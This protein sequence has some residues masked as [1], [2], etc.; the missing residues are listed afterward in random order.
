MELKACPVCLRSDMVSFSDKTVEAFDVQC[1]RCGISGPRTDT[2]PEA[3]AQWNRIERP[4]IKQELTPRD[5][6]AIAAL[7]GEL[8]AQDSESIGVVGTDEASLKDLAYRCYATAD[9]MLEVREVK[10]RLH[11][12]NVQEALRIMKENNG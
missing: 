3:A 1:S 12:D 11:L 5:R 9:A 10:G 8:A 2:I 4:A 6:F 7:Q